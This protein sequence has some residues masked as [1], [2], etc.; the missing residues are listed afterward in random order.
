MLF[1]LKSRNFLFRITPAFETPNPRLSTKFYL[2][3]NT[4][5]QPFRTLLF[6]A[7]FAPVHSVHLLSDY[8]QT[9]FQGREINR[10]YRRG[11]SSR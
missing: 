3:N 2:P 11:W 9:Q 4:L 5:A 1:S 10:D 6:P 7:Y 8:S